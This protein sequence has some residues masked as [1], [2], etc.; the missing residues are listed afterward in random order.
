MDREAMAR[1]QR[2]RQA[3]DALEFE[4]ARGE[5]LREQLETVIGETDGAALDEAIF[6]SMAPE[7]V[8][9]VREALCGPEPDDAGESDEAWTDADWLAPEEDDPALELAERES[10]IE[11][12]RGELAASRQRES[13][14]ERYLEALAE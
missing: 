5:A 9:V 1:A 11:R 3:L 8:A 4:R 2:R 10:E 12:L 7:D 13:A 6:A 14:L